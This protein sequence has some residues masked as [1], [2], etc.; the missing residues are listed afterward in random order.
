MEKC[1]QDGTR[2]VSNTAMSWFRNSY[3]QLRLGLRITVAGLLAYVLCR[4]IG[5]SQTYQGV[6]TA[7]IVMQGSVGASVK[8]VTD[9]FIGSLGGALWAVLVVF[10]LQ[11]LLE[12]H[13]VIVIIIVLVPMAVLAAFKPAYRAAPSTAIILLLAPAS[14]N[15]PLA[16][17]IQRIYGIGIG[18]LAAFIVALLV[19]PARVH[20][21]FAEV[22]GQVSGRMSELAAILIN[23]VNV[24]VDPGT[25]QRLHDEVRKSINQAELAADEIL[26][27]RATHLSDGPDPLPMCRALR[28]IRNDLS[29]I[30]RVT[31]ELFPDAVRGRL[32]APSQTA[33]A[34]VAGFLGECGN[35]ISRRASAPS[36][37][38]CERELTGLV[39][40]L[41][42]L[43]WIGPMRELPDDVIGRIYGLAFGLEQLERNLTEL[44]ERIKELAA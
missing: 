11:T 24:Q 44:I 13:T 21:A 4:A 42:G 33:A 3:S 18:S 19:L 39:S 6:L 5:I 34:A 35:A 43:R 41:R 36:F 15:G 7:V 40:T 12:F 38:N 28:R 26:R 14:I 25:I 8:A 30:G 27:E 22:A 9:R 2:T 37:E 17:A 32:A 20:G 16:P 31:S 23:G 10:A 1:V 29:M